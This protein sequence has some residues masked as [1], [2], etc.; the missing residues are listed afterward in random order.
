LGIPSSNKEEGEKRKAA[1]KELD[2]QI[3]GILGEQRFVEYKYDNDWNR[4]SLRKVAEE[5]NIP[6]QDA[7][8]VF[9]IRATAQEEAAKVRADKSLKPEQMQ[10]ALNG[11]RAETEKAVGDVIGAKPLQDY[12]QKGSWLKNLNKAGA[13]QTTD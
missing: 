12:I 11:I 9:D 2:S 10:A 4:S 1:Q 13:G 3:R 7:L 6:K 5:H 8:K